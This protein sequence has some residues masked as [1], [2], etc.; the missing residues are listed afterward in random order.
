[1]SGQATSSFKYTPVQCC[2]Q[3]GLAQEEMLRYQEKELMFL[4]PPAEILP[5]SFLQLAC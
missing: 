4:G 5:L 2:L 1:M 3:E